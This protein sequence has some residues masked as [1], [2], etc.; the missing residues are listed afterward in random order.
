MDNYWTISG[1]IV[2]F[3]YLNGSSLI[4]LLQLTYTKDKEVLNIPI[5]KR[6]IKG[7]SLRDEITLIGRFANSPQT[8]GTILPVVDKISRDI[9]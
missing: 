8:N 6:L 7:L 5:E 1:T 9:K 4:L 3:S 2:G